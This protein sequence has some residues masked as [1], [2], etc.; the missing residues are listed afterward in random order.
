MKKREIKMKWDFP[1]GRRKKE[2]RR[3]K[4][5]EGR[6]ENVTTSSSSSDSSSSSCSVGIRTYKQ[7][8]VYDAGS[9][10]LDLAS[11]PGASKEACPL[12]AGA[13]H[14]RHSC[15][16]PS[17]RA[18]WGGHVPGNR[19]APFTDHCLPNIIILMQMVG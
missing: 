16:R 10:A 7:W 3:S 11:Y 14:A 4:K 8:P 2:Q 19:P 13:A 6:R 18:G 12:G 1:E 9:Q 15:P 17:Q 5:G